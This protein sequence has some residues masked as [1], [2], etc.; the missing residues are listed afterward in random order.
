MHMHTHKGALRHN[1]G[2]GNPSNPVRE[3]Q[4]PALVSPRRPWRDSTT[5]PNMISEQEPQSTL[6]TFW[7]HILTWMS[8]YIELNKWYWGAFPTRLLQTCRSYFYKEKS[9]LLERN[10]QQRNSWWLER[11]FNLKVVPREEEL[12]PRKPNCQLVI[13]FHPALHPNIS[14]APTLCNRTLGTW[15]EKPSEGWH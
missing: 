6:G 12:F 15:A 2:W 10:M 3:T 11:R 1:A 7:K 5:M 8:V 4:G 13:A 14:T 9:G